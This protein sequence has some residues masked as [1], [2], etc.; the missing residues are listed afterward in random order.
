MITGKILGTT[1][2]IDTVSA[3]V[4]GF[5]P[6]MSVDIY[7]E[8]VRLIDGKLLFLED[9]LSRL[10]HSLTGS[11]LEFPGTE[12]IRE[13]LSLL[14]KH[15]KFSHGNIRFCIQGQK[16]GRQELLCYFVPYFYPE[17]EM[18][19]KGVRLMTFPYI[20]PN[21]GI[22]KWDDRFRN[23]V[24]RFIRENH[25]YEAVLLN[26]KQQITEG[27]RSNIFFI[28]QHDRVITAPE[29]DV[30]PGITRNYVMAICREA[31]IK[32]IQQ[33]IRLDD[34]EDVPSCFISG[35]SPKILPV[36]QLD[37]KHFKTDHPLISLLMNKFDKLLQA[38]LESLV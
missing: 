36:K 1:Y 29:K 18:Y 11:G 14:I 2:V 30:L 8:V 28:N 9:H 23:A 37:N 6:D 16:G 5:L 7:Y 13:N 33:S 3:D 19:T 24:S 26:K 27:S 25:I 35:T 12:L 21:P 17:P 34:I 20:R 31:N 10:R 32:I 4:S 15:N 22:K 38:N